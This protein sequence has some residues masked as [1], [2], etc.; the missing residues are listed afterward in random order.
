MSRLLTECD[1]AVEKLQGSKESNSKLDRGLSDEEFDALERILA[2]AVQAYHA[3]DRFQKRFP[4][5]LLA[6][7]H[8]IALT[9][10]LESKSHT[11]RQN[12][13]NPRTGN[14][15]ASKE[16]QEVSQASEQAPAP[17]PR[18]RSPRTSNVDLPVFPERLSL[19]DDADP[20]E[21]ADTIRPVDE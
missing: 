10:G 19:A 9:F 5:F 18:C 3:L 17:A 4:Q 13:I 16:A 15:M 2:V 8:L 12:L 11:G 21:S 6:H 7:C 14:I 20:A 1:S